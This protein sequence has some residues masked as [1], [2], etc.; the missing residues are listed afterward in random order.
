MNNVIDDYEYGIEP[1]NFVVLLRTLRAAF[2][3]EIFMCQ[4][5]SDI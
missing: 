2:C 4:V 5:P 3:S 1:M